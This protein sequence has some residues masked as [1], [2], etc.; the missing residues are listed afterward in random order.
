MQDYYNY[1]EGQTRLAEKKDPGGHNSWSG[2]EEGEWDESD[3][4]D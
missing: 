3:W 4:D 2:W 1:T